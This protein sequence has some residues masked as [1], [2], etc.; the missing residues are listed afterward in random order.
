MDITQAREIVEREIVQAG[1]TL[2]Y[3]SGLTGRVSW[4]SRAARI[5]EI[6]TRRSLY[7][8]LH[9]LG[10]IVN[11]R[12]RPVYLGEYQ[13]EVYAHNR[14]REMGFAVPR[15][16]TARAKDYVHMKVKR[17]KRRGLK[18]TPLVPPTYYEGER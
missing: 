9:E 4:V 15:K 3:S 12:V 13:A 11:G 18:G 17:A 16:M 6:K 10:H 14:M 8:A 7:I 1:Y 5:P 2:S